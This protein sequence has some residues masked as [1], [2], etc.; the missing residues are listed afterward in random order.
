MGA[1]EGDDDEEP[2][3]NVL[4]NPYWITSTEITKDQYHAC[5]KAGDCR[6]SLDSGFSTS[7]EPVVYVNWFE[8]QDYCAWVG[9]RLPTEA[10]WEKAGRGGL[11]GARYPWGDSEV[12]CDTAAPN[13]A[14][15]GYC[16]GGLMPVGSFAENGF[17]LFD[18]AGNAW[19]WVSDWYDE[20]Y[21][22]YSPV[23][24]PSGPKDGK[25]KVIRGGGWNYTVYGLRVAYR[26]VSFPESQ[27]N[28]IGFR[29]VRDTLPK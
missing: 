21:Y 14:Q 25:Y 5:V 13:G 8:A 15:F 7:N 22:H 24:D 28:F 23:E 6:S 18:M 12:S 1:E 3:H 29:C 20:D 27:T 11:V 9:G 19:E 16:A 10:E 17:G 26:S 4:L 2:M